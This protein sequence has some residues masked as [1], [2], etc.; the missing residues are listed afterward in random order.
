MNFY[1]RKSEV[2]RAAQFDG[3]AESLAGLG[4]AIEIRESGDA[5]VT[6]QRG[7]WAFVRNSDQVLVNRHGFVSVVS[8]QDFAA[9]YEPAEAPV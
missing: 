8:E 1:R 6:T 4:L 3:T 9:D 5:I 7:S 2:I